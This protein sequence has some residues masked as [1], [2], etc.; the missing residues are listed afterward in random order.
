MILKLFNYLI[1][2]HEKKD[3]A[4]YNKK[5]LKKIEK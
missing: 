5:K 2:Q 4:Y 1:N 3:A